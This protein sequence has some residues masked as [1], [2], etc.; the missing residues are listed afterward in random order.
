MGASQSHSLK[1]KTQKTIDTTI[2][3][4]KITRGFA[5]FEP[6]QG[7]L[8]SLVAILTMAK[9]R[10]VKLILSAARRSISID[11]SAE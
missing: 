9:V 7:V 5:P 8:D 2:E 4:I 3:L 10:V 1:K 6:A 11:V